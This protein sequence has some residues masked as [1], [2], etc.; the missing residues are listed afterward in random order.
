MFNF[1]FCPPLKAGFF[2]A[3]LVAAGFSG[4]I[5]RAQSAYDDMDQQTIDRLIAMS[6]GLTDMYITTGRGDDGRVFATIYF[7]CLSFGCA[8][9]PGPGCGEP[10]AFLMKCETSTTVDGESL[11]PLCSP[12][13]DNQ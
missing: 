3:A 5:G 13:E 10:G 6:Q 12:G 9:S 1:L 11:P 8:V 7:C 4:T 2:A